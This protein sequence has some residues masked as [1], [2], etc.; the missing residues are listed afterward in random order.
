MTVT[1]CVINW[2]WRRWTC[3]D[4]AHQSSGSKPCSDEIDRLTHL[5]WLHWAV[6]AGTNFQTSHSTRLISSM[7]FLVNPK[8]YIVVEHKKFIIAKNRT[9][10]KFQHTCRFMDMQICSKRCKKLFYRCDFH[11]TETGFV[12]ENEAVKLVGITKYALNVRMKIFYGNFGI[13]SGIFFNFVTIFVF[14]NL[15]IGVFDAE[16]YSQ[17]WVQ[18]LNR[19]HKILTRWVQILNLS[20]QLWLGGYKS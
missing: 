9:A 20:T 18:I 4:S 13:N 10:I 3:H 6:H 14:D 15:R 2:A 5:I 11:I 16:P 1:F 7:D 12:R 8:V 17:L 19:G